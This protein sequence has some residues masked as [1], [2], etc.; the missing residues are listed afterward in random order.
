[1]SVK[2]TRH[3][4]RGHHDTLGDGVAPPMLASLPLVEL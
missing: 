1:V 3:P 4:D 2:K